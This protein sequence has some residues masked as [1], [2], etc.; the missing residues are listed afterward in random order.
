MP[1]SPDPGLALRLDWPFLALSFLLG[2]I[3]F[4]VVVARVFFRSDIRA[5]GSG[6]IGAANALRTLGP[7]AGA[8]VLV[9]DALKGFVAV[10]V[11]GALL[12]HA[13][14]GYAEAQRVAIVDDSVR[15]APLHGLFAIAGHCYTPWLRFRGGKGVATY[16]GAL[17]ALGW[18]SGVA[19]IVTWLAVVVPT[20]FASAGS[21]L[22]TAVAGVTLAVLGQARYGAGG[23]IFALASFGLILW[24]HR[25]NVAR[26]RAGSET[27]LT[28]GSKPR[29]A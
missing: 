17:F 12:S 13:I 8:A 15:F 3:P 2:S 4:G 7:K 18:P 29:T 20:R 11:C 10:V 22:A 5:A 1:L 14:D 28:F 6:N 9:F 27:K 19:F 24:K 16:L 21:I 23:W 25:E 26:L